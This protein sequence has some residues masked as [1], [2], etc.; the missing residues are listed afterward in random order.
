M[1]CADASKQEFP[2]FDPHPDRAFPCVFMFLLQFPHH[3]NM[4][5][6]LILLT[7]SLAYIWS[8]SLGT[9]QQH[10]HGGFQIISTLLHT[11]DGLP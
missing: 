5:N 2:E 6:K 8:C 11:L 7:K 4:Y 9:V 1:V 3:Q 10:Q